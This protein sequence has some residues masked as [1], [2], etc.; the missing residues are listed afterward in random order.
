[1]FA[2]WYATSSSPMDLGIDQWSIGT[3]GDYNNFLSGS[4]LTT[5]C[6][7]RVCV[8]WGQNQTIN[9]TTDVHMGNST[10]SNATAR[11]ALALQITNNGYSLIDGG[12]A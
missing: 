9:N 12:P 2:G 4:K 11:A 6:Y 10:Y 3:I 8:A 5:T 1:M 7:D